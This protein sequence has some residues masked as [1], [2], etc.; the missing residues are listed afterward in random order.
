M[1]NGLTKRQA[2]AVALLSR[3]KKTG[4]IAE[5]WGVTKTSVGDVLRA[6]QRRLNCRTNHQLMYVMG[7]LNHNDPR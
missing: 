6:A 1:M 5:Q 7:M 2:E 3:G 4:E